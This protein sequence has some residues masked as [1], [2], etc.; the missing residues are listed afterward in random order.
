M[1]KE[2][3]PPQPDPFSFSERERLYDRVSDARFRALLGDE[4]TQVHNAEL[5]SNNY[6]EFV[7]VTLSRPTQQGRQ[8]ATFWGLGYHEYRERWIADYWNWYSTTLW[9]DKAEKA[10]V[11]EEVEKLIEERREEI[12]PYLGKEQQS[13]RGKLFELLADLTDEDGAY[14]ELEDLGD[15]D[16]WLE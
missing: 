5:S 16:D 13:Q 11:K 8:A 4:L 7:F 3:L 14:T 2:H 15:I 6:G 10:L 1:S 12:A 9:R